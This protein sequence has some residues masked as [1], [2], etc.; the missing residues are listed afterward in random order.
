M[1]GMWVAVVQRVH[2]HPRSAPLLCRMRSAPQRDGDPRRLPGPL[3]RPQRAHQLIVLLPV[4][5]PVVFA[6][7][8][9]Q[10][11]DELLDATHRWVV[12]HARTIGTV[13][14]AAFSVYLLVKGVRALP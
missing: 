9:G 5:V 2:A 13:V 8:L 11:A 7:V 3:P 12:R 6:S 1:H 4:L 14:E 10:R